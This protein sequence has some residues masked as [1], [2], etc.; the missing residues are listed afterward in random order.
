M[1]GLIA[2]FRSF[3]TE[4]TSGAVT[5]EW[6]VLTAMLVLSMAASMGTIATGI[7]IAAAAIEQNAA[8]PANGTVFTLSA[9]GTVSGS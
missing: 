4:D 2:K 5:V 3:L 6:T 7:H 1:F 9:P 8:L